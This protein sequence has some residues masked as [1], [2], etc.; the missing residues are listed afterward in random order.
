MGTATCRVCGMSLT[1][2]D[3]ALKGGTSLGGRYSIGRVL[4]Q[5][6]FGIT[7]LGAD[8]LL[9]RPVAIKELVPDGSTRKGTQLVP[10]SSL[11]PT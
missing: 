11:R 9:T 1:D 2:L 5:G 3:I 7:Y 6:G 10:P 8:K 4:G